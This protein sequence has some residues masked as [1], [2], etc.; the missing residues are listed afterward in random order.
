MT[1]GSLPRPNEIAEV[2]LPWAF[3]NPILSTDCGPGVPND[4][5][6]KG[7]WYLGSGGC[8][9]KRREERQRLA[10]VCAG[11]VVENGQVDARSC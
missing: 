10:T 7:R 11:P 6:P 2:E 9:R 3:A 4:I 1:Q 8:E 5:D